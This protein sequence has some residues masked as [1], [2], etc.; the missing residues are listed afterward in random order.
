VMSD[1]FDAFM[2]P[3]V[4]RRKQIGLKQSDIAER[5]GVSKQAVS[6]WETGFR[7]PEL[8]NLCAWA[9]VLGCK[10]SLSLS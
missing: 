1:G 3:L 8:H 9:K 5:L 4:V 2:R 10:V 6:N 7:S